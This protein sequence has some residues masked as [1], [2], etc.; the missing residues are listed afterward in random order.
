MKIILT[1]V[2][3][4][5]GFH[6]ARHLL[7]R[8]DEVIGIDNINKYYDIELKHSRLKELGIEINNS[9]ETNNYHSSLFPRL[10]FYIADIANKNDILEIFDQNKPDAV[11]N[12]AAQAGVRYS[13]ENPDV[14]IQ[15]NIVGFFNLLEAT[16]QSGIK[17]FCFSSSS[18]VY[19]LNNNYPFC[20]ENHTDHPISLYAAT[21]KANEML[22]HSY[23]SLYNIAT[24]GLR[25]FT[26][27]G[28][29]GRP[30]MAPMLFADAILRDKPIKLFNNGNMVRDFT[31]I[32]DVV[33]AILCV[34]DKPAKPSP[35]WD[36][37]SPN[38]SISSAPYRIYNVGNSNPIQLLDFIEAIETAMNKKAIKEFYPMQVGDVLITSADTNALF[39]EFQ[40]KPQTEL[41]LGIKKFT[42]W[43]LKYYSKR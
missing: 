34:I 36:A 9:N 31:Y 38:P 11:C 40:F 3:G 19:G 4:F 7:E 18:S 5:I 28:P 1:G 43:F 23:S 14:Y 15:S 29:W 41:N 16:R 32:D 39:H 10:N 24:T 8:G 37:S 21:K 27:Y 22:A 42:D 17:N 33:A 20:E 35:N 13:I 12:I 25:F 26:V 6:L 2:A 30:D